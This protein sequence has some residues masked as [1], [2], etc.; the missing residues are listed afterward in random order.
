MRK[1]FYDN[2]MER[3]K[4][5]A[6]AR[7]SMRVGQLPHRRELLDDQPERQTMPSPSCDTP[8]DASS[9]KDSSRVSVLDTESLR[10]ALKDPRLPNDFVT[11]SIED[12]CDDSLMPP[13]SMQELMASLERISSFPP[14]SPIFISNER[15]LA[16]V[17]RFLLRRVKLS[18]DLKSQL[19]G[20]QDTDH[21]EVT[22]GKLSWVAPH[23][24]H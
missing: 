1:R 18:D 24:Q 5:R 6:R 9:S 20:H 4:Q 15:D 7:Q 19:M 16:I 17:C 12:V 8:H 13:E 14:A 22:V 2:G 21:H 10:A 23:Y 11:S 3:L